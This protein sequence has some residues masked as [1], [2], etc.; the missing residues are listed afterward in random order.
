LNWAAYDI[1]VK[2]S[3]SAAS[4]YKA[5]FPTKKEIFENGLSVGGS[6]KTCNGI[7]TTIRAK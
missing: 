5:R 2:V 6:Y 1:A 7:S 3:S 4:K